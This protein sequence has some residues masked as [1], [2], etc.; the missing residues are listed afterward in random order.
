MQVLPLVFASCALSLCLLAV[1]IC[2]ELLSAAAST[3]A[4][5]SVAA[6]DDG[7]DN[8]IQLPFCEKGVWL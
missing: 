6:D 3:A 7:G 1:A 8:L 4:A 2:S 5:A